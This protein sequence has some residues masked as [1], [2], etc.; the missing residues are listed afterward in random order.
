TMYESGHFENDVLV[1]GENY[2]LI[3]LKQAAVRGRLIPFDR[4]LRMDQRAFVGNA[5]IA[6]GESGSL[7]HYLYSKDLLRKFYDTYKAGYDQDK[8][9]AEALVEVCGMPLKQLEREW[10]EWMMQ[11]TLPTLETGQNGVVLGVRFGH[12]NDG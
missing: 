10:E 12:G 2:R 1:P 5:T 11:R 7:L 8:T 6:Y 9:G 3:S 4:L